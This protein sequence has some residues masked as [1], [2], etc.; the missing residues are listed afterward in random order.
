MHFPRI[1]ILAAAAILLAA[2][3]A[4]A[5]PLQIAVLLPQSGR[6]ARAADAIRDGLLA[7][8]YQDAATTTDTPALRFYD[9]DSSD[10]LALVKQ[11]QSDGAGFIIGP[12]D[13]ERV[14]RLVT[15]GPPGVPLLALNAVDAG[16]TGLL[17]FSL[18]PEDEIR[19]LAEWMNAQKVKRPLVITSS[20]DS[21]QRQQKLFEA[22]WR[23]YHPGSLTVVTLDAARK[24]GIV[25]G[26]HA[27]A[28]Q[29]GGHDALFLASP[30]LA[31]Q[32]LPALTYYHNTL[33]LYSLSGAWDP[34]A[35]ASGQK[36]LDGLR[37]CDLPWML[38]ATRPEQASLY[39]AI[40]RPVGGY[41]RLQAFGGDAWTLLKRWQAVQDGEVLTLRTGKLQ[42][43]HSGHL[44]RI[45]T[46]A[47]VSNG[48]ATP[49]W[50]PGG[51][52]R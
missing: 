20:E 21:G 34:A 24:G 2:T 27:L 46:C 31:T 19:R 4:V 11:V 7:A 10:I 32:V 30:G 35:D 23:Q 14:E 1:R 42:A 39:E 45:P 51:P 29:T 37:F 18:A 8:Y 44:R 43:D 36:D 26:V 41:D 38:D 3:E 40:P 47:E 22:A 17:Q 16:A 25:A 52:G 48:T 13:R 9:S 33:P 6:M 12:L 50:L 5:R 49:L 15:A 28:T